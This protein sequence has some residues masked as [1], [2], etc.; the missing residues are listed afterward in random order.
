M[1]E[2]DFWGEVFGGKD[3]LRLSLGAYNFRTRK[4]KGSVVYSFE[5]GE[6][7][8]IRVKWISYA[9]RNWALVEWSDGI[10][11]NNAAVFGLLYVRDC[12]EKFTGLSIDPF[13]HG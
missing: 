5:Y 8:R 2:R 4:N 6:G 11:S 3:M 9:P 13:T 12:V 1:S 7:K 10:S